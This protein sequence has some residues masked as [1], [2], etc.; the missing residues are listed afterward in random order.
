MKRIL[1][2]VQPSGNPHLGNYFGAMKNHVQMQD[3]Y[4]SYI[5]IA[6][7]H[8]LT[9]V[10]DPEKIIKNHFKKKSENFIFDYLFGLR[11]FCNSR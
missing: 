2:G 11:S 1:S 3:E 5:F 8:A 6:D 9:T 4:E 10:R 7:L